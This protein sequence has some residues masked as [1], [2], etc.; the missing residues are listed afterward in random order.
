MWSV[1]LA[2]M[3]GACRQPSTGEPHPA[4]NA[5][6]PAPAPPPASATAKSFYAQRFSRRPMPAEM[7]ELGRQLFF[8]LQLSTFGKMSCATCHD[9]RFAFGPPNGRATQLGG[10]GFK[11]AGLRAVPSLR[12]LQ[13]LPPFSE[14]H[15]DE[16]I[17]DST[18]QGPTGGYGW[19]GRA[20]SAHDQARLPLTSPFEMANPDVDSVVA[21]VAQGPLAAG[22]RKVFG[23]DVFGDPTRGSTALLQCLEVFQ[24]SPKDFYP[25]SSRYDDYLRGKGTLT[26]D[27]QRGMALFNDPKK[28]NCANCHPSLIRQGA[29]PQFTDYGFGA[30]GVPRNR[31][32]P[33]NHDP[34]FHDMGL[35]GPV[36]TDMASHPEYC[37]HFR[38]P[39]LR[40]V[41]L[42]RVFF[43][44]GVYHGL[45]QVL[46]FYA[47]RDTSPGKLYG[48]SAGRFD[49]LPVAYKKNVNR[50]RPFGRK[51]GDPPPLTKVERRAIITF[52]KTLTDADLAKR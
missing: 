4:P 16:A 8:D 34:A 52:L 12:Y 31:E 10:P 24:Q 50:E 42:R 48:K 39:G 35:C 47:E 43:H 41:A 3:T 46:D 36:R 25:Y 28:G 37:G 27:E 32:L 5:N 23:D 9:P 1:A 33:A 51:P 18:D 7:V 13:T 44:N 20:A 45:D 21:R 29:F 19:D 40:N 14:H 26:A 2:A 6:Q 30:L 49:D 22:F 38:V 17:D 11:A 15:Y